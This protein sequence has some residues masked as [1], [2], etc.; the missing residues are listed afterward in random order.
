MKKFHLVKNN[1]YIHIPFCSHICSYCDFCKLIYDEK[2]ASKYINELLKEE[3]GEVQFV[4]NEVSG[5]C[6]FNLSYLVTKNNKV[7][8]NIDE[9]IGKYWYYLKKQENNG[10][11][12]NYNWILKCLKSNEW[13]FMQ[14]RW[15]IIQN[16]FKRISLRKSINE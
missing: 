4:K 5:I 3:I 9:I 6:T 13:I 12:Q 16:G 11:I 15:I 10:K 1:L 7:Y 2:M 14:F 8:S